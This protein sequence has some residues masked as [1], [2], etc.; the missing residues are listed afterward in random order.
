M[1]ETYIDSHYL[2]LNF[3]Q[4]N[5]DSEIRVRDYLVINVLISCQRIILNQ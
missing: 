2:I 1:L 5:R 3:Y 4:I